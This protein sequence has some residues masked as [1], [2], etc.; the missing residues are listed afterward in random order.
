MQV[1]VQGLDQRFTQTAVEFMRT[2][3]EEG[4]SQRVGS[5][6]ARAVLAQFNGVYLTDCTQVKW[7]GGG[8][9]VGVR[10]ELQGGTLQVSLS[11]LTQHDQKTEVIERPLPPGAVHLGDLGF[12]KLKRFGDWNEQ[13]VYWLSRYKVGTRLMT[14]AGQEL[15]LKTFLTGDAPITLPVMVGTHRAVKAFLLA[16]PLSEAALSKRQARMKDQARRDQR[17]ISHR[18]AQLASWTIYLTNIADLT[19]AQANILARTRWQIELLFK[20]WKSHGKV[21]ISRSA[22]PLRQQCE[23]Y[24]KLLGVVIAHWML[25]VT[26]WRQPT[27]GAVDAL[28]ILRAYVPMIRRALTAPPLLGQIFAWLQLDLQAAPRLSKRRKVPLAFQLWQQFDRSCP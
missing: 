22:N 13:G 4:V 2:L 28:R 20:L 27:L 26:G 16:A 8:T 5:E 7:T 17:P 23:G 3:L 11:D 21:M 24:A 1:S 14:L 18:Q 9:K 12:F 6:E 19:F 10:L 25:L 15:D